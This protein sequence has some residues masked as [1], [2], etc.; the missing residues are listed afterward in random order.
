MRAGLFALMR[1]CTKQATGKWIAQVPERDE[2]A[3][4]HECVD[5]A[6]ERP[7]APVALQHA[8]EYVRVDVTPRRAALRMNPRNRQRRCPNP[9]RADD[10][11]HDKLFKEAFGNVENALE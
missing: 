4:L 8:V 7:F 6:P 11:P 9:P 1:R 2:G 5:D 3:R 10:S